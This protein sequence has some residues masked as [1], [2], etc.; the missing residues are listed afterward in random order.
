MRP[1]RYI[2]AVLAGALAAAALI[3]LANYALDPVGMFDNSPEGIYV[4][5][6]RPFKANQIRRVPHETLVLGS[7]KTA[8]FDP[9]SLPELKAFNAAFAAA[10]PEEIAAFLRD[11]GDGARL[12]L[13]GLDPY[14][15]ESKTE[16]RSFS[17]FPRPDAYEKARHLF[18]FDVLKDGALAA[19]YRAV[20]RPPLIAPN[21][22]WNRD[23][24][25]VLQALPR[26]FAAEYARVLHKLDTDHYDAFRVSEVRLRALQEVKAILERRGTD[27]VVFINPLEACVLALLEARPDRA[28]EFA[29]LRREIKRIFPAAIDF[30]ASSYSDSA[31]FYRFD[32]FHY[33]TAVATR[34]I[35]DVV[36]RRRPGPLRA[37]CARSAG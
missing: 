35:R 9:A 20:G 19:I 18:S 11:F 30:S 23:D 10:Y 33:T 7:S 6:E 29:K 15:F 8:V 32:P 37:R 28:R 12:V 5:R 31:N 22:R 21:G 13:I 2:G 27:Y 24:R 17:R 1:R 4:F 36:Q 3:A 34:L 25:D 16:P 26:D 14:M